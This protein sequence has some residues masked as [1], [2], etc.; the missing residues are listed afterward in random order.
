M[1]DPLDVSVTEALRA[2]KVQHE[3]GVS[4]VDALLNSAMVCRGA[5]RACF[6]AA[7]QRARDGEGFDRLMDALR[8]A[9]PE[10]ECAV[11]VAGWQGGSA[12]TVLDSVIRQREL[13]QQTRRRVRSGMVLPA[14]VLLLA[15]FIAPLPNLVLNGGMVVYCL[16]ALLP[17]A[18]AVGLWLVAARI[19]RARARQCV[20]ADGRPGPPGTLDHVLLAIPLAAEIERSRSMAEFASV[21]A[22]LLK[23]GVRIDHALEITA[24][25]VRNGVYRRDVARFAET[26][27]RGTPLSSALSACDA[28]LWPPEFVSA[29]VVGEQAGALDETLARLAESARERYVRAIDHIGEWTPKLMYALVALY[30]IYIIFSLYSGLYGSGGIVDQA[31]RDINPQ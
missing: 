27:Q 11:I 26:T 7:A 6:E 16:S 13:W 18:L 3:A 4:A 9:L 21:L 1:I 2:W 14:G 10:A 25:V 5:A 20:L 12:E 23:S 29:V 8:P 22:N 30:V 24:R 19:F 28:S 31:L 17:V 15:S